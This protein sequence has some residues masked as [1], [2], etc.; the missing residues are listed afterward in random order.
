MKAPADVTVELMEADLS[1]PG[2]G[3]SEEGRAR[4]AGLRVHT[5]VHSAALV[6]HLRPYVPPCGAGLVS[7]PRVSPC[8]LTL[9]NRVPRVSLHPLVT[10]GCVE[11]WRRRS[12]STKG[13]SRKRVRRG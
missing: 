1:Q 3:L 5:V 13:L 11:K 8:D 2:L 6:N 7:Q 10:L 9:V 12:R 4:L